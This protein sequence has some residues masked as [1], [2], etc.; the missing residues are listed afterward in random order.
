MSTIEHWTR[1]QLA[2]FVTSYWG[3]DAGDV[4]R[5]VDRWLARGDG[6]AIYRNHDLS[7]TGAGQPQIVSYGSPAAQLETDIPPAQL[8]DI[9]GSVNWRYQLDAVCHNETE[10]EA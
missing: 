5:L 6:A 10:Q 2:G 3:E 7:S 4:M 1:D 8:P 9:G